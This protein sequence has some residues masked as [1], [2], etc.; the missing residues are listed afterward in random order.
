ML[1]R[2]DSTPATAWERKDPHLDDCFAGAVIVLDGGEG[3]PKTLRVVKRAN[4]FFDS[5]RGSRGWKGDSKLRLQ[6]PA[7]YLGLAGAWDSLT[8]NLA[9]HDASEPDG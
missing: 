5:I 7:R 4:V 1:S 6:G 2:R 3:G 8:L 9:N